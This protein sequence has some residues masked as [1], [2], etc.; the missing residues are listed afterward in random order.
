VI[1]RHIAAC[2]PHGVDAVYAMHQCDFALL[3]VTDSLRHDLEARITR[4]LTEGQ[5][6]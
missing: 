6:P 4:S 3:L 5:N 1:A 2:L